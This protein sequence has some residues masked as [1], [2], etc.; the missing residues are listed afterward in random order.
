MTPDTYLRLNRSILAN[1]RKIRCRDASLRGPRRKD[2]REKAL[3]PH[4]LRRSWCTGIEV[5]TFFIFRRK[6]LPMN[7]ASSSTAKERTTRLP[8][9]ALQ[10]LVGILAAAI[11][12]FLLYDIDAMRRGLSATEADLRLTNAQLRLT[13]M[14]LQHTNGQLGMTNR[15]LLFTNEQLSVT[16]TKLTVTNTKLNGLSATNRSL[17]A[18]NAELEK[19]SRDMASMRD[20]LTH[21]S[22]KIVHAK[23]LF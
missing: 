18:T 23:L 17:N 21:M 10:A 6:S 1:E 13:N 5:Y 14:Q 11:V 15:Q 9:A 8:A 3:R 2:R 4:G 20:S 7:Y 19:M 22:G 16:N 12:A